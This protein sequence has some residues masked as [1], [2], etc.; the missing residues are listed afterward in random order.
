ME[1]YD[2]A[3]ITDHQSQP[4]SN[5]YSYRAK[6]DTK[7]NNYNI[8]REYGTL[9]IDVVTTSIVVKAKGATN[10]YDGKELTQSAWEIVQADIKSNDKLVVET[11]GGITDAGTQTNSVSSCTVMRGGEDVSV[12]YTF[13]EHQ[14][15]TLSITPRPIELTSANGQWNYN[16][17]VHTSKSVEV[18]SELNFVEGQGIESYSDYASIK[19]VFENGELGKENTFNYTLKENTKAGNYNITKVFGRLKMLPVETQLVVTA[20]SINEIYNGET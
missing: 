6:G 13:G 4:I 7:L 20:N 3:K 5:T 11:A 17:E 19:D 18:T 14:T 16:G 1:Y 8:T 2:F 10:I 9:Q 15:G 12:N